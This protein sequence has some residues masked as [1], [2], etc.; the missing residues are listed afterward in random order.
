MA[1]MKKKKKKKKTN[2]RMD[3]GALPVLFLSMKEAERGV[4]RKWLVEQ[5]VRTYDIVSWKYKRM[6][7]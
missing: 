4:G 1:R 6:R 5:G 3:G 7:M 2:E